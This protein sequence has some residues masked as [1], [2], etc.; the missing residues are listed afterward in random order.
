MQKVG[1]ACARDA[2]SAA[3]HEACVSAGISPR[4]IVRTCAGITGAARAEIATVMRSLISS[5]VG[6]QIDV[7]ADIDIAFEA[8]FGQQPGVMVIAGTGAIAYGRNGHGLT[9]RASGWGPAVSDEGSGHWIGAEAVRLALRAYDRGEN[10][11]LL[12]E[13]IAKLEAT[14]F[15]DFIVRVNAT[16]APD[17]SVLFPIVLSCAD[18]GD[19]VATEILCRAA[20]ELAFSANLVIEKLFVTKSCSVATHGGV[21]ASSAMLKQSFVDEL[22]TRAPQAAILDRVVDPALGALQMARANSKALA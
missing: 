11:G 3:I 22:R 19:A 6:G 8:A 9:A 12:S 14:N 2:L 13:V 20:R 4:Q 18:N 1:E 7:V 10:P 5:I 16:P 17:F 21:F 15:E